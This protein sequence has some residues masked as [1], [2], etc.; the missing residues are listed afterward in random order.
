MCVRAVLVDRGFQPGIAKTFDKTKDPGLSS[1]WSFTPRSFMKGSRPY[2]FHCKT[3]VN[4][5][6]PK[7]GALA[8]T[9][10]TTSAC[11]KSTFHMFRH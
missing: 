1:A 6:N 5:A 8:R 10:A 9:T 2:Y 4:A 11:R 7:N 3:A